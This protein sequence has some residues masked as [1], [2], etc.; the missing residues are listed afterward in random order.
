MEDEHLS[1]DIFPLTMSIF[2]RFIHRNSSSKIN[3]R[4]L[5]LVAL[6]S[7]SLAKKLRESSAI[8]NENEK[9]FWIVERENYCETEIF[10]SLIFIVKEKRFCFIVVF[11][12]F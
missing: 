11:S 8:N 2:D 1:Q 5:Q 4:S 12:S 7:Y 9:I 6:C 10:V 3:D